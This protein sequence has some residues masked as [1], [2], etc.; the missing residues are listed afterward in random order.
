[1]QRWL[2]L[3]AAYSES[4]LRVGCLEWPLRASPSHALQLQAAAALRALHPVRSRHAQVC[5]YTCDSFMCAV[6]SIV[7]VRQQE[8]GEGGREGK[9][10]G[11]EEGRGIKGTIQRL[12]NLYIHQTVKS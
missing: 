10:E 4:P 3:S 2:K 1:M 6:G 8:G 9:E 11:R 12:F 7:S 5:M